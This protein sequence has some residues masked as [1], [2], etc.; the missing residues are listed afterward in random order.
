MKNDLFPFDAF[1]AKYLDQDIL[2]LRAAR[3]DIIH[4]RWEKERVFG[5]TD[6]TD[7]TDFDR[8]IELMLLG[9][10]I[11][12]RSLLQDV[13]CQCGYRAPLTMK[14]CKRCGN[15]MDAYSR[16]TEMDVFEVWENFEWSADT[17][18]KDATPDAI[19]LFSLH[20]HYFYLPSTKKFYAVSRCEAAWNHNQSIFERVTLDEI[21]DIVNTQ[22]ATHEAA[23][24]E[25]AK[26]Y[27]SDI[28]WKL[29]F[30]YHTPD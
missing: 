21:V 15:A 20:R 13:V 9:K 7:L 17:D 26:E 10:L 12:K 3:R 23:G 6:L 29:Q 2:D 24:D 1:L 8:Q 30:G 25:E 22:T 14:R 19:H 28:F 11:Y 18:I 5:K 16:R 4:E 27:W